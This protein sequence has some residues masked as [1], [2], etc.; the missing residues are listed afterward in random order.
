M[1][2]NMG[3]QFT[4]KALELLILMWMTGQRTSLRDL[5]LSQLELMS[6]RG[7][8]REDQLL[9][10]E[11]SSVSFSSWKSQYLFSPNRL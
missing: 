3:N 7:G 1:L 2:R 10:Q 4:M 6:R 11:V 8:L 9:E 5:F